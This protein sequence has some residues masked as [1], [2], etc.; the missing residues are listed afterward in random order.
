MEDVTN[1]PIPKRRPPVPP[2]RRRIF[3]DVEKAKICWWAGQGW[4]A[5]QIAEAIGRTTPKAIYEALRR[6]G[7]NLVWKKSHSMAFVIQIPERYWERLEVIAGS[8]NEEP[9]ALA[10]HVLTTML[11]KP[12]ALIKIIDDNQPD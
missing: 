11:N 7:I 3:S 6:W 12:T 1:P 8:R 2:I 9:A 10:S 5:P 4:S